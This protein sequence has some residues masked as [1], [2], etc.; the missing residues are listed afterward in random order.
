MLQP[1]ALSLSSTSAFPKFIQCTGTTRLAG[2][3]QNVSTRCSSR[4]S[5]PS[6]RTSNSLHAISMSLQM[7]PIT[8][9]WWC[10]CT[11]W[12]TCSA[13]AFSWGCPVCRL[14]R[15]QPTLLHC[16]WTHCRRVLVSLRNNFDIDWSCLPQPALLCFMEDSM[17]ASS[18]CV[19]K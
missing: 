11:L 6:W 17:V 4:G 10:I 5:K 9:A 3:W 16:R 2:K 19:S 13:C 15:T 7:Q 14:L 12:T 8:P 18:E 1:L